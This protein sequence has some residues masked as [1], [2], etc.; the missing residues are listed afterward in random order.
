MRNEKIALAIIVLAI[1]GGVLTIRAPSSVSST[2]GAS[3]RG[4]SSLPRQ[5]AS[6]GTRGKAVTPA[7]TAKPLPAT[8]AAPT[9]AANSQVLG[10]SDPRQRPFEMKKEL[11][12]YRLYSKKVF[13]SEEEKRQKRGLLQDAGL[14]RQLGALFKSSASSYEDLVEQQNTAVDFLL[15]ALQG[16]SRAVAAEVLRG[17]IQDPATENTRLSLASRENLAGAKAEILYRWSAQEP[18]KS[19]EIA[20]WLPGP[21]SQRIWRNVLAQQESNRAESAITK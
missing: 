8:A 2:R 18:A 17:V 6:P 19:R 15:E 5:P 1:L 11:E 14:I 4:P 13:M 16:E 21:V 20:Q 12:E 10:G 9:A 7:A 3:T